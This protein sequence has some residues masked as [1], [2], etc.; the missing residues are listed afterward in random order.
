MEWFGSFPNSDDAMS[1]SSTLVRTSLTPATFKY[2]LK[3][4]AGAEA[5]FDGFD[6]FKLFDTATKTVFAVVD[7]PSKT[8]GSTT[9]PSATATVSSNSLKA[10]ISLGLVSLLLLFAQ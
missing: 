3:Q 4:P 10:S 7:M 1:L 2:A 9:R 6:Q 5:N 8:N